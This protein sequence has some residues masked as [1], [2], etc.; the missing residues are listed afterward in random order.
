VIVYVIGLV[1][2]LLGL[3]SIHKGR[4]EFGPEHAKRLDRGIIVLILG[5]FVPAAIGAA[6]SVGGGVLGGGSVG[7]TPRTSF[8]S[9][10][11][12]SPEASSGPSSSACSSCGASRP[13]RRP[14]C[15]CGR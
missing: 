6:G 4:D 1:F 13:S 2:G 14:C 11:A 7:F 3:V 10:A 12:G 9:A 5:I 15:A 8:A